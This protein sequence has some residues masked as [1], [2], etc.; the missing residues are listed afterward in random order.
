MSKRTDKFHL[1]DPFLPEWQSQHD[2]GILESPP[3]I[4]PL[5]DL[6]DNPVPPFHQF[7][8]PMTDFYRP[9]PVSA[10]ESQHIIVQ[11]LDTGMFAIA[12][13]IVGIFRKDP[14]PTPRRIAARYPSGYSFRC[15][16]YP[17]CKGT[18]CQPDAALGFVLYF[19]GEFIVSELPGGLVI[20]V[21]DTGV[22]L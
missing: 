13:S 7:N 14:L 4:R 2:P 9:I 12:S 6:F 19:Y 22:T 15:D 5:A 18:F 11:C 21:G 17:G 10:I 3:G 1:A 20:V 8:I 16:A